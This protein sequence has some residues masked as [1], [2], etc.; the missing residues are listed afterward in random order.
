MQSMLDETLKG[1][2][3]KDRINK[4]TILVDSPE[5]EIAKI[6]ETGDLDA[7]N[8]MKIYESR[9]ARAIAILVN[10]IDPDVLILGGGMSNFERI[11][12]NVPALVKKWTF[13]SEFTTP[14]RAAKHGDSSGVRGAAWLW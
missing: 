12:K 1:I 9:L 14:I 6:L 5:G 13:G 11:Y 3:K 2:E 8:V 7:E 10:I 4:S